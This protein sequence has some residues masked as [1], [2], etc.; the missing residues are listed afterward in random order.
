MWVQRFIVGVTISSLAG[1]APVFAK[2]DKPRPAPVV[3]DWKQVVT[4]KDMDRIRNWRNAFVK[5][6][7]A[8]KSKGNG[9]S[10]AREGALLDPDASQGSAL[11]PAGAYR[12]RVIKL[13][14]QHGGLSYVVYPHFACAISDQGEVKGFAKTSGSQRPSGLIFPNDANRAIFLGTMM[15]GDEKRAIDYGRDSMR[16]MAGALEQIGPNRWRLILPYPAFESM[17][18]VIELTPAA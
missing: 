3:A 5:A 4:P 18:D 15:L 16:D 17:M 11:P 9:P 1:A 10:M 2:K 13:G 7:D 12:C 8:A 6:L 14:G